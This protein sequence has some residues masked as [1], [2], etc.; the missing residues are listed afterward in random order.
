MLVVPADG[1]EAIYSVL[2]T[3]KERSQN[4]KKG[5]TSHTL[6]NQVTLAPT[7]DL[8]MKRTNI[9][10]IILYLLLLQSFLH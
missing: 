8:T 5:V 2:R 7:S 4:V 10:A 6:T 9:E 1:G 3:F